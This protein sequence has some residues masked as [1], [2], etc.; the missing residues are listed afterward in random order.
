MIQTCFRF[1]VVAEFSKVDEFTVA[2]KIR[3]K[4][5]S[6]QTTY[7]CNLIYKPPENYPL[8]EGPIALLN[9][10][11]RFPRSIYLIVPQIA[12]IGPVVDQKSHKQ[13]N[14]QKI[15]GHPKLR[16]DGWMEV[17]LWEDT[18]DSTGTIG[19]KLTLNGMDI[20]GDYNFVGLVVQGIELRPL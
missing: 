6:P 20:D 12:N 19:T 5:L 10:S 17:Q 11:L 13:S 16:K 4:L 18:T 8:I 9:Q 2:F 14:A 1:K 7:S 3:S 15:K